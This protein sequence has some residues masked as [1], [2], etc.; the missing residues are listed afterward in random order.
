[1]TYLNQ[2][3][4]QEQYLEVYPQDSVV[5]KTQKQINWMLFNIINLPIESAFWAIKT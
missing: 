5:L 3:L 4:L 2:M 1:M